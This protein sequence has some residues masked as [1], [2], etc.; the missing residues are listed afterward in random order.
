MALSRLWAGGGRA[1]LVFTLAGAPLHANAAQA[2]ARAP[3]QKRETRKSR[4][5]KQVVPDKQRAK[6]GDDLSEGGERR[7][8]AEL[9]LGSV[10]AGAVVAVVARGIWEIGVGRQT[11]RDCDAGISDDVACTRANPGNGGFIAAGLSFALVI[12]FG[13][14]SGLLL[15]RGVKTRRAYKQWHEQHGTVAVTAGPGR[16]GLALSLRF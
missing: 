13:V 1:L 8:V 14:A 15:S 3:K 9:V 10:A 4:K 12:P 5:S 16:A 7:G 11:K 6:R 2:Q